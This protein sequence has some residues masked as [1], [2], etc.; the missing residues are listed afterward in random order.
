MLVCRGLDHDFGAATLIFFSRTNSRT[1]L[2]ISTLDCRSNFISD[3]V[4]IRGVEQVTCFRLCKA[5]KSEAE[6]LFPPVFKFI[7][8]FLPQMLVCL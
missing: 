2:A 3:T 5:V 1:L 4:N 8:M 7:A 6:L